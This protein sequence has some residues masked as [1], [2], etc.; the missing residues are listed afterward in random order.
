M[1]ASHGDGESCGPERSC[2]VEGAGILVR[3]NADER[4]KPE[5]AVA[6]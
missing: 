4:N 5:I 6:P 2:D 1:E 3:L